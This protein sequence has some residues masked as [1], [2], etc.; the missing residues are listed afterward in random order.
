[1][2]GGLSAPAASVVP[3]GIHCEYV[4]LSPAELRRSLSD[5]SW[6]QEHID[7]LGDAW[8]EG[9]PL[10][11]EK[12]PF[13]SIEKAWHKLHHLLAAHG[14]MPVDII[15]GGVELPLEDELDYGPARY[16][17]P[18]D[19][20]RAGGFLAA[21]PFGE[22]AGTTTWPPCAVPRPISCRNPTPRSPRTWPPCST[23]MRS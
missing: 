20:A 18:E 9:E 1:M 5:P 11:P 7:E 3:M 16:L 2:A 12:A 14:G 23:A 13:F 15:H 6:A 19:V 8:A 21:T 22:L 10:S 4:R 17:S